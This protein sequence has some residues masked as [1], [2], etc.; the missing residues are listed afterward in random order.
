MHHLLDVR[1]GIGGTHFLHS[2][3]V[4]ATLPECPEDADLTPQ[5]D[6][7]LARGQQLHAMFDD[8][9]VPGRL[10]LAIGQILGT[11]TRMLTCSEPSG[12]NG[13]PASLKPEL[14]LLMSRYFAH[15]SL[16]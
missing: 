16:R 10:T 3:Q 1:P 13:S 2:D 15:C 12:M 4:D 14:Q 9:A 8:A 7:L 11:D 6:E 5:L